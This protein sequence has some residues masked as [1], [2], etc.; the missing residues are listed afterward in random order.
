MRRLF[1]IVTAYIS[2]RILENRYP[3]K[4]DWIKPDIEDL[5]KENAIHNATYLAY[6]LFDYRKMKS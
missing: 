5:S 6:L 3:S 1:I 2:N 4:C